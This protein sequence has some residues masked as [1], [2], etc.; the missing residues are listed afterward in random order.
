MFICF[1]CGESLDDSLRS[2][3]HIVPDSIGG[4]ITTWKVCKECNTKANQQIDNKFKDQ[5]LI[6]WDR[7]LLGLTDKRGN[8]HTEVIETT[9]ENGEPIQ[10]LIC[11][12]GF[13][14]VSKPVTDIN[15]EKGEK[16]TVKVD[17]RHLKQVLKKIEKKALKKGMEINISKSSSEKIDVGKVAFTKGLDLKVIRREQAKII[18]GLGCF[19]IPNFAESDTAE[20]LRN[21]LWDEE[22]RITVKNL[23]SRL[24]PYQIKKETFPP[25]T[26]EGNIIYTYTTENMLLDNILGSLISDK[27]HIFIIYKYNNKLRLFLNIFGHMN[28]VIETLESPSYF[29]PGPVPY[30][31][32]A[33]VIHPKEKKHKELFIDEIKVIASSIAK[34]RLAGFLSSNPKVY[35][36]L[37]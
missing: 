10:I 17:P 9:S 6:S 26:I 37:K 21:Y 16:G 4:N 33:Y 15:W 24:F 22:G 2:E 29:Y 35:K 25:F 8:K 5:W 1:Y 23:N 7:A 13:V 19:F 11:E 34:G 36:N 28:A 14:P 3:E 31:E 27:E 20:A 30:K 12:D 32:M 18:L